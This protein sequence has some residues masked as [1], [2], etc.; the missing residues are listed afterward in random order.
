MRRSP[1]EWTHLISGKQ[2]SATNPITD[3]VNEAADGN[4]SKRERGI[5][6]PDATT[7]G[8]VFLDLWNRSL[9]L[10]AAAVSPR[11]V[12]GIFGILVLSGAASEDG[13]AV[14]VCGDCGVGAG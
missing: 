11:Y 2:G 12:C 4:A 7:P 9:E 1:K 8:G 13:R 3:C 10:R 6:E 5:P 14:F